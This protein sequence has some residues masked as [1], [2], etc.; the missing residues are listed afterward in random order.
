MTMRPTLLTFSGIGILAVG[1]VTASWVFVQGTE[2]IGGYSHPWIAWAEYV[3]YSGANAYDVQTWLVLGAMAAALVIGFLTLIVV[4]IASRRRKLDPAFGGGVRPV[5][6]GVTDNHGHADWMTMKE[7]RKL[8]PGPTREYGGIVVGEA[9]RV[10]QDKVA[11]IR[12]DPSNSRTWGQG[13]KADLLIDRCL[14]GSGH[15]IAFAG[16]GGN[17]TTTMVSTQLHWLSSCVVHDPSREVADMVARARRGMGQRVVTM[18]LSDPETGCN[19]LS[20]IDP[21]KPGAGADVISTTAWICGDEPGRTKDPVFDNAGRN[22]VACL[23]AHM[24]WDDRLPA[25]DKSLACFIDGLAQAEQDLRGTLRRIAATSNST[26][27]QRLAR[28]VMGL[29][30]ETFGGVLFN[31]STFCSWLYH[32]ETARFLSVNGRFQPSDLCD[33]RTSVYVQVPLAVLENMPAVSRTIM[34][35]LINAVFD[36]DGAVRGRV[37]FDIDEARFCGPM[38]IFKTVRDAGRKYRITMRPWYQSEADF[39]KIWDPKEAAAWYDNVS[40]RSY[41]AVQN[42]QTAKNLSQSI[43]THGV[44]AYSEGDNTGRTSGFAQIGTRSTG[45]NENRHEI[46]RPLIRP[47]ELTQDARTDEQ[48]ILPRAGKP[49]RCG[50]AIYFR[51]REMVAQ[52]DSSRFYKEVAA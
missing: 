20:W 3:T 41:A 7:L 40:Y 37:L 4:R 34:G 35:A 11:N 30:D 44:M 25:E 19:I 26:L 23:I 49:I 52:I 33:G 27:A 47:E 10:D 16:S 9:Y 24:M 31:A 12:F 2:P 8:F 38:R 51:R 15:S 1:E 46:S 43:G 36:A 18:D 13:G 17:K 42:L 32:D 28:T 6:R 5:E 50:R 14:D 39:E 22:L 45:S 21:E 48:F 29:P